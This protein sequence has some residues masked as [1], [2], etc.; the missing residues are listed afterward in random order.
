MLR[1]GMN[2][3]SIV[4]CLALSGGV[5]SAYADA[6]GLAFA[7][8]VYQRADGDDYAAFTIMTLSGGGR[9][10]VRKMY[11][12]RWD[13]EGRGNA[14][15]MLRFV[16]PGD[17]AGTGLLTIDYADKDDSDQWVFLPALG[18]ERRI[19]SQRKGGRFVGSDIFYEDL[20]DRHPGKDQHRLLGN[21]ALNGV[22]LVRIESIPVDKSNSVYSRRLAWVN[23]DMLVPMRIDYFESGTQQPSKRFEV[24]RVGKVSGFWTI[25][26]STMTDLKGGT[27]TRLV[28]EKSTYNQGIPEKLFTSRYLRQ[29]SRLEKQWRP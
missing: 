16:A 26:E 18:R 6:E 1:T 3:L 17:V 27:S 29:E 9:D 4:L 19:S 22:E 7:E 8:K 23:P 25:L 15:T 10:R 20:R 5:G 13:A 14:K 21:E 28:D 2:M 12:Y 24:Q 11:T